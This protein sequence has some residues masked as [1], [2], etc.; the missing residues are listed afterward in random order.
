MGLC[1]PVHMILSVWGRDI[2]VQLSTKS[3]CRIEVQLADQP[4]DDQVQIN[5][6]T[7]LRHQFATDTT[8]QNLI[9]FRLKEKPFDVHGSEV[10]NR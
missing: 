9:S 7:D 8:T 3:F 4:G 1:M 10:I 6:Q 2:S 5:L